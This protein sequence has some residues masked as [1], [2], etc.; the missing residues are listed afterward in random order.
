[1]FYIVCNN[2]EDR[3]NLLFHFKKANILAVSHYNSLHKSEY[4]KNEH[5]GRILLNSDI[6]SDCLLR[7]PLYFEITM[8]EMDRVIKVIT[9]FYIKN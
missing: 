9:D 1:M 3:T 6:F 4:Y 2:F 8:E 7:L 5:D